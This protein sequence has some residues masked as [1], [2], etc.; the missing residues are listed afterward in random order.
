MF[1]HLAAI[2]RLGNL[3]QF[4]IIHQYNRDD[5]MTYNSSLQSARY[6]VENIIRSQ[7]LPLP[8][9][10]RSRYASVPEPGERPEP[11]RRQMLATDPD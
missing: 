10:Q 4:Q 9:L 2:T 7:T 1:K 8:S 6:K 3:I 5:V 11:M